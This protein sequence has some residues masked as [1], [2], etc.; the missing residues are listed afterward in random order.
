MAP[1]RVF[2]RRGHLQ[3][4]TG[5][6]EARG[7]LAADKAPCFALNETIASDFALCGPSRQHRVV[8]AERT[9]IRFTAILFTAMGACR[10]D[11]LARNQK[12]NA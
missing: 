7:L 6:G 2:S 4:R 11:Q 1:N 3:S 12:L 10:E 8:P 5:V 9:N